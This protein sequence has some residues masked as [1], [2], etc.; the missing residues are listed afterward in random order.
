MEN[1]QSQLLAFDLIPCDLASY[2]FW[3]NVTRAIVLI[4]IDPKLLYSLFLN[5]RWL[6][7][8]SA[9]LGTHFVFGIPGTHG[10]FRKIYLMMSTASDADVRVIAPFLNLHK[11]YVFSKQILLEFD[12]S[13]AHT[14]N[15]TQFKGNTLLSCYIDL[16][17]MKLDKRIRKLSFRLIEM[18]SRK[19]FRRTW[20]KK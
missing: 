14:S 9:T 17:S 4:S 18:K 15:D 10:N 16:I 12:V 20:P 3:L 1:C 11:H 6:F 8:F 19:P 5:E 7:L 2:L 13:I